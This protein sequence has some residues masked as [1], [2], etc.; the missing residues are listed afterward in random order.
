MNTMKMGLLVGGL[1]VGG[2]SNAAIY[3]SEI[4]PGLEG[5]GGYVELYNSSDTLVM[6]KGWR[7]RTGEVEYAFEDGNTIMPKGT[8]MIGNT[9]AFFK[10]KY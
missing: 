3:V 8:L 9:W 1:A 5:R 7:L 6:M 2:L 4:S 10:C